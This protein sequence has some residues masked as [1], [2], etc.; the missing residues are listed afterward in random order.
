MNVIKKVI[1]YIPS[2]SIGGAERV[3][4]DIYNKL[5]RNLF[6]YKLC[7]GTDNLDFVNGIKNKNELILFDKNNTK[8]SII[9]FLKTIKNEKPDLIVG[10][11]AHGNI[12]AGLTSLI[13]D[14]P[15]ILINHGDLLS[16][17]N[18]F[19]D[20]SIFIKQL[21]KFFYKKADNSIVVSQ[22]L[23]DFLKEIYNIQTNKI[24]LLDNPINKEYIETKAKNDNISKF[25]KED[26]TNI[27]SIG[28]LSKEKGHKYLIMASNL[29]LK[30][31]SNINIF[32]IG[33]G[34][35]YNNLLN[36]IRE[37]DLEDK[38]FLLGKTNNPYKYL[39]R[40]DIFILPSIR[41]ASPITILEAGICKT[42][43]ITTDWDG[44][45]KYNKTKKRLLIAKKQNPHSLYN[46]IY[47]LL[48]SPDLKKELT[49]NMYNYVKAKSTKK[50]A[51]SY[52]E[53]FKKLI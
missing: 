21:L 7:V 33:D 34:P 29:L 26:N 9:P 13:F 11:L 39:M 47:T 3:T 1:F 46:K 17:K 40:S 23:F 28:R 5:N 36:Q 10:I 15:Y 52:E 43:I 35:E 31:N 50:I 20:S 48:N 8:K 4:I 49:F 25:F 2:L 41:E 12:I 32:I 51:R 24:N 38:I 53:L 14:V 16:Y 37:N 42:P 30:K 22:E 18:N 19:E 27:I 45:N 44:V 6:S